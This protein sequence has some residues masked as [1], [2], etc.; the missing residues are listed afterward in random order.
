VSGDA[1]VLVFVAACILP[2]RPVRFVGW[3]ISPPASS[4]RRLLATVVW[5]DLGRLGNGA[6]GQT[7]PSFQQ[8]FGYLTVSCGGQVP[9]VLIDAD[10][11]MVRGLPFC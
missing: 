6:I 3:W 10:D 2:S 1:E 4:L 11:V 9:A 5:V 7:G 8:L